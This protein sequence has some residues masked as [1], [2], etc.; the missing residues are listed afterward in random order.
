L[1][2]ANPST[3]ASGE[4]AVIQAPSD[5]A[6]A[7]TFT[8]DYLWT[9]LHTG[10]NASGDADTNPVFIGFDNGVPAKEAGSG[11]TLLIPGVPITITTKA[12]N[13]LTFLAFAGAPLLAV[14]SNKGA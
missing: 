12:T 3:L 8:G 4:P 11:Y 7:L 13:R 5:V 1:S 14:M 2:V 9:I 6:H 10:V